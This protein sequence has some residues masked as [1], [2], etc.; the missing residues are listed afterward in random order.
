[1]NDISVVQAPE[2]NLMMNPVAL[3]SIQQVANLMSEGKNSVPKH[4]QGNVADCMA[5]CMQAAQW[6]MSPYSV[7]WKTYPV[8]G[9]MSYE[10][11]LINA[12]VSSSNAIKG[13]F[14][15][16]YGGDWS[17]KIDK[18]S[19]KDRNGNPIAT[20]SFDNSACVRCGAVL[21][22]EQDIT[23]GEWLYPETIS[24]KNSVLW[25]SAPKQQGAYLVV[26][27]W[28]RLYCPDVILGV[29]SK[30]EL[31]TQPLERDI[32]KKGETLDNILGKVGESEVESKNNIPIEEP[33]NS[34]ML[35]VEAML[36]KIQN[37]PSSD[38]NAISLAIPQQN[39]SMKDMNQLREAY[40]KRQKDLKNK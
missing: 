33:D 9:A 26:K 3:A 39:Y 5:V 13:R 32:T 8:N 35:T 24:V 20:R 2:T 14:K 7:A 37:A 30:E 25:V 4:L 27:Y 23:W 40:I 17:G 31:E 34:E 28:A 11:Q 36:T 38:L 22:G 16:E 6:G 19:R 21:N 12:V 1:M 10:A 29:Y 18:T 15:Y